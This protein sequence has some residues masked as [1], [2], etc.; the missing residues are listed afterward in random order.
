MSYTLH[1]HVRE[2]EP[3]IGLYGYDDIRAAVEEEVS[4]TI[5]ELGSDYLETGSEGE[6]DLATELLTDEAMERLWN[7]PALEDDRT[8]FRLP[9][10]AGA[11]HHGVLLSLVAE[12]AVEA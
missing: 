6:R 2:A 8:Q 4:T 5:N 1:I 11:R 3:Y 12:S 7:Q 9:G 10:P